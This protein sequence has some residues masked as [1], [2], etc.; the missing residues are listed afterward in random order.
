MS[1]MEKARQEGRQEKEQ[2]Y[3]QKIAGKMLAEGMDIATIARYTDLP[4]TDVEKLA[5]Q[6]HP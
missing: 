2:E 6:P 3:S 1:L 5:P 4:V